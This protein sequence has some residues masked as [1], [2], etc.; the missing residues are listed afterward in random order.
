MISTPRT[1][2]PSDHFPEPFETIEDFPS[3]H[4]IEWRQGGIHVGDRIITPR[5]LQGIRNVLSGGG[6]M[7]CKSTRHP[8]AA[9]ILTCATASSTLGQIIVDA[10]AAVDAVDMGAHDL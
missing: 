8:I 4:W 7:T 5:V 1:P 3:A 2:A 10:D 6:D 9:L